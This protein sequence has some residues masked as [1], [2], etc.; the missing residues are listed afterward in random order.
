MIRSIVV[1]LAALSSGLLMLHEAPSQ[2]DPR[3]IMAVDPSTCDSMPS[4]VPWSIAIEPH[5]HLV[6]EVVGKDQDQELMA[7][8]IDGSIYVRGAL[9]AVDKETADTLNEALRHTCTS[10]CN[11]GI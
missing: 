6:L 1:V 9:V 4:S 5:R 10:I 3:I 8:G 2:P 11:R 7:I